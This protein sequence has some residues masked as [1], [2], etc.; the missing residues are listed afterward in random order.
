MTTKELLEL[1]KA[2]CD[3]AREIV[4]AKNHDYTGDSGD[5]FSNFRAS[6]VL[7]VPGEIGIMIR[8]LD[9]MKRI[10]TFVNTGTLKVKGEGVDD[11]INDVINYAI[12]L[13]GI[14]STR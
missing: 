3:A 2:T 14:I 12:L 7:G 10:Q 11:A 5:P 1:H 4:A 6:E 8:M 13:K 9:K